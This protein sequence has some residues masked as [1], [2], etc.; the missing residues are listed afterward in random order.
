MRGELRVRLAIGALHRVLR[1]ESGAREWAELAVL[2]GR[3]ESYADTA[4]LRGRAY[5]YTMQAEDSAGLRS[6]TLRP[7]PPVRQRRASGGW[8]GF[9]PPR[10]GE[11]CA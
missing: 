4:V 3:A 1:R 11:P 10:R 8:T 7:C 5:E 6:P 9:A 2:A